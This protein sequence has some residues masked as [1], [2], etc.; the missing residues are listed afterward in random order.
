[1]VISTVILCFFVASVTS[2][3]ED[4]MPS[5]E[6]FPR[7]LQDM[8]IYNESG[9]KDFEED[10]MTNQDLDKYLSDLK[11]YLNTLQTTNI[12]F[13]QEILDIVREINVFISDL[14]LD[15][16]ESIKPDMNA[17]NQRI[18]KLKRNSIPWRRQFDYPIE[19]INKR[20]NSF[21]KNTAN[22]LNKIS[23]DLVEAKESF[24][25]VIGIL[26]EESGKLKGYKSQK[27]QINYEAL[28]ES[29]ENIQYVIDND[30]FTDKVQESINSLN[31][32]NGLF[33]IPW[34]TVHGKVR[35]VVI[36]K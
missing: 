1:M 3:P 36:R 8:I 33:S 18:E 19:W 12:D 26:D 4:T 35:S 22:K 32:N 29:L 16:E 5:G 10:L 13:S 21:S 23:K 20:I 28:I 7:G 30:L 2:V 27:T 34:S 11:A 6:A 24:V 15:P 25:K 31:L 17:L 14:L 9:L